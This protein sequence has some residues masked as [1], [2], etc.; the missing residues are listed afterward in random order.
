MLLGILLF[1]LDFLKDI[2]AIVRMSF[3]ENKLLASR[4]IQPYIIP[5]SYF[6]LIRAYLSENGQHHMDCLKL[7][8]L[9][10][11]IFMIV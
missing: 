7:A 4:D 11:G 5:C 10:S 3:I 1:W 2:A 8:K 6:T 9:A